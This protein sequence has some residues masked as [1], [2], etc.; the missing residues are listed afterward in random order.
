[1]VAVAADSQCK[2]QWCPFPS[3]VLMDADK[4]SSRESLL[5][6]ASDDLV[7]QKPLLKSSVLSQ[8]KN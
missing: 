3:A 5:V 1:M 7:K 8:F 2:R 4:V 6:S